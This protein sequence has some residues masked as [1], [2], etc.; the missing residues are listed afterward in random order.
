MLNS[1]KNFERLTSP[2]K[3]KK[4]A[5]LTCSYHKTFVTGLCDLTTDSVWCLLNAK[6]VLSCV[7]VDAELMWK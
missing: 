2:I 6:P 1:S 7:M 5:E 3:K 4:K